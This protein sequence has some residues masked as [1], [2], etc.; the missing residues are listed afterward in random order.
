MLIH[1]LIQMD[2]VYAKFRYS[3]YRGL[4][5][6]KSAYGFASSTLRRE[7]TILY[8]LK[9]C[10]EIVQCVGDGFSAD[11]GLVYYLLLEHANG[12][13]LA[14]VLRYSVDRFQEPNASKYTCVLLRGLCRMHEKGYVHC[15][16]KPGHV[17]VFVSRNKDGTYEEFVKIG[18]FG[19]A[20]IASSDNSD[21]RLRELKS[22]LRIARDDAATD[23]WS[24][25]CVVAEMLVGRS[26]WRKNLRKDM[27]LMTLP[28]YLSEDAKDF[29]KRC[30]TMNKNE[31]WTSKRL[32]QHPFITQY[33]E[34]KLD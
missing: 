8:D 12:G 14:E 24:L 15:S 20:K 31:R 9:D 17:L 3:G 11:T 4:M 26:L 23:I 30:L 5:Y 18:G 28:K 27:N 19:S 6:V 7:K 25:G 33:D 1:G 32:L 16:L 10:P 34:V 29:L 2:S 13:T 22:L 21:Y